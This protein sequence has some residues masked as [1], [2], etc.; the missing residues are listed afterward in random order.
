MC[1]RIRKTFPP[2]LEKSYNASQNV[3]IVAED[4]DRPTV[5][6]N[7]IRYYLKPYTRIKIVAT[8]RRLHDWLL[9]F[10]NQ[11]I[12]LYM[13]K[14][15]SGEEEYPS[16]V[17]WVQQHYEDFYSRHTVE[18]IKRYKQNGFSEVAVETC[19]V[20][21]KGMWNTT[22][23]NVGGSHEYE[24]LI[25]KARY[26]GKFKYPMDK[27]GAE[28]LSRKLVKIMNKAQRGLVDHL[29]LQCLPDDF[30]LEMMKTEMK[31]E[32]EFFPEWYE[33]RGGDGGLKM[34]FEKVSRTKL[35][36]LNVDK[37]L[38]IGILDDLFTKIK[39]N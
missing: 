18:L 4:L 34:D 25:I 7:R 24:R 12:D 20:I 19:L 29:G 8:Y 28:K 16:F 10:Y 38:D 21:K 15:A 23:S 37:I 2:F 9:S 11:I 33:M 6:F 31:H 22:K 36:S 30:A 35:C 1:N 17:E 13:G 3:I 27:K 32:R 26:Q 5:D 39:H 14:Y